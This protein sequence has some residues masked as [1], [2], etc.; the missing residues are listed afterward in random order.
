MDD[1][2]QRLQSLGK[3]MGAREWVECQILFAYLH[4]KEVG[5]ILR[6]IQVS[7]I[8]PTIIER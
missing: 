7:G 2:C 8:P 1:Q 3:F 6:Q 5:Y 4:N